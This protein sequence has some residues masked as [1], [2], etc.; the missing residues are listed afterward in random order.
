MMQGRLKLHTFVPISF[1][2]GGKIDS[3]ALGI[4]FIGLYVSV[5]VY[6]SH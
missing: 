4:F 1:G 2:N 3:Y 6:F 5:G